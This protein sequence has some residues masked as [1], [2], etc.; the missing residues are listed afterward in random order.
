MRAEKTDFTGLSSPSDSVRDVS[1]TPA[2]LWLGPGPLFRDLGPVLEVLAAAAARDS[3]SGGPAPTIESLTDLDRLLDPPQGTGRLLL[4]VEGLPIEDVGLVKRF[5]RR[6]AGWSLILCGGDPR[7]STVRSLAGDR[8]SRWLA[9]PPDLDQMRALVGAEVSNG[10]VPQAPGP[11]GASDG[12]GGDIGVAGDDLE[13]HGGAT[14]AQHSPGDG[15][16]DLGELVEEL[17]ASAALAD[18]PPDYAYRANGNLSLGLPPDDVA[19]IV[20]AV[21]GLARACGG[22]GAAISVEAG[23]GAGDDIELRVG[24]PEGPLAG[25]GGRQLLDPQ[26]LGERLGASEQEAFGEAAGLLEALGGTADVGRPE[27]GR[28]Q[29]TLVLPRH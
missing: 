15:A 7:H 24:F 13:H 6:Y 17:L 4:A 19:R 27:D 1:S 2:A 21:L 10:Q 28:L 5:V 11:R 12:P 9:W 29:M 26:A 16:L 25:L 22:E 8:H 18:S 20:D 3:G 23:P 14:R